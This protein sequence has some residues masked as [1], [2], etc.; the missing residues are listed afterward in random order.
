MDFHE[1]ILQGISLKE[2]YL[3]GMVIHLVPWRG[4]RLKEIYQ[5]VAYTQLPK[6]YLGDERLPSIDLSQAIIDLL[7]SK[8]AGT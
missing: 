5:L 2:A 7:Q 3:L 8:G 6:D 1:K 4:I